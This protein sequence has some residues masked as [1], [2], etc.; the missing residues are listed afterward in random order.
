LSLNLS[1]S[2][3]LHTLEN[4]TNIALQEYILHLKVI[5]KKE[6]NK[7]TEVKNLPHKITKVT[8]T[9]VSP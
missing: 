5:Q 6:K 1:H 9:N 4:I 2:G 8:R 3:H 7:T